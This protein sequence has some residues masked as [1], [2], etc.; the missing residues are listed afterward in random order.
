[1]FIAF[2]SVG[3]GSGSSSSGGI[4]PDDQDPGCHR[5]AL[6]ITSDDPSFVWNGE[7][8]DVYEREYRDCIRASDSLGG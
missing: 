3:F 2:A 5:G 4:D 1:M 7:G 6:A 8:M